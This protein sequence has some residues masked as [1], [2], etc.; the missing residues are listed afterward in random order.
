[1][2]KLPITYTN[3]NDVTKTED[4]HFHMSVAELTDMGLSTGG[5]TFGELVRRMTSENDTGA[6]MAA[7]K[8]VILRSVGQRSQDGDMFYK[9]ERIQNDFVACGAYDALF[10]KLLTDT[11]E[12]V[13]FINGIMPTDMQKN[14]EFQ[15]ALAG[16]Q[17]SALTP[18]TERVR[19]SPD[20]YSR[21]ELVDM[22][23]EQFDALVG[24]DTKKMSKAHLSI[25]MER[26]TSGKDE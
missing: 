13:K 19:N 7:F 5:T 23:R 14:P 21:Q 15:K 18:E 12:I 6:V 25:L 26:V 9:N 3:F 11:A 22:P 24:T 16:L 8:D 17:I 10:L 2:L 4:F 1:V 20:D